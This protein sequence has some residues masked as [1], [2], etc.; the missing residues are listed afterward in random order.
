MDPS[1]CSRGRH[2]P[3]SSAHTLPYLLCLLLV[4]IASAPLNVAPSAAQT[5]LVSTGRARVPIVD[6]RTLDARGQALG[7]ASDRAIVKAVARLIGID[8]GEF[9]DSQIDEIREAT[10]G[11]SNELVISRDILRDEAADGQYSIEIRLS[12]REKRLR[13]ALATTSLLGGRARSQALIVV[14]VEEQSARRVSGTPIV[15]TELQSAL[16]AAGF[17]VVDGAQVEALRERDQVAS[18]A[19]G[20]L[21]AARAIARRFAAD[22]ALC[23]TAACDPLPRN[24]VGYASRARLDARLYHT[25]TGELIAASGVQK[26]G[27]DGS[28]HASMRRAYA[29]AANELGMLMAGKFQAWE[30]ARSA[31]SRAVVIHVAGLPFVQYARLRAALD[32]GIAGMRGYRLRSYDDRAE[33]VELEAQ[34][35]GNAEQLA[36]AIVATA[37]PEF[38]LSIREVSPNRI[39]LK[40]GPK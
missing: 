20:D 25:D 2:T 37:F 6:G 12:I 36:T 33:W 13:A 31:T 29:N 21:A 22:A 38:Q 27:I 18:A 9:T 3:H 5:P 10:A 24:A 34:Y 40:A 23:G 4:T 15:T 30:L 16:L 35:E 7:A 1:Q 11:L 19:R 14:L 26:S 39:Q 28:P 17:R 8:S 32:L